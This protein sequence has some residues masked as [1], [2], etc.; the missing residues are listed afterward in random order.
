M[1]SRMKRIFHRKK[2]GDA[3]PTGQR[4]SYSSSSETALRTSRYDTTVAGGR[5]QTGDYPIRGNDESLALT[6]QGRKSSVRSRRS[7]GSQNRL[8]RRSVTP[9]RYAI[10]RNF[11]ASPPPPRDIANP[12]VR[13]S[14]YSRSPP[15]GRTQDDNQKRWSHSQLPQ[16]FSGMSLGSDGR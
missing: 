14:K 2:D 12:D 11:E 15:S 10:Q 16:D 9:D 1:A 6:Q 7:S 4:D 13:A 5:P 3:S 8:S